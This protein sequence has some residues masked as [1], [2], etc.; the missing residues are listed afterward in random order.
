MSQKNRIIE[1]VFKDG[2]KEYFPQ[3]SYDGKS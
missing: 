3:W 2:R 1:I